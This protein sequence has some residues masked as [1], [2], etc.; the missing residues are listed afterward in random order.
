[1]TKRALEGIRIV[2]LSRLLPGPYCSMILAD[3]G[4][5]V[6]KVEEPHLGDPTRW[7]PPQ[8]H[9]TGI[10]FLNLN[11][12]KRSLTLNLKDPRGVAL[13]HRLAQQ[14]DVI[15][16]TFRPGV[17]DRLGI[18]YEAIATV[19]PQIVYCSLTGYGQ[20][21]PY[22]D[23]SGHDLNYIGLAGILG[24]TADPQGRPTIPGTQMADLAGAMAAAIAILAALLARQR[25]GH[26]QYIDVAMT[27]VAVGL[28]TIAA[29]TTFAGHPLPVGGRFELNGLFPFFNIYETSDGGFISLGALE[30]KF[31]QEFCRVVGRDD[32]VDKQ[33]AS[34][35]ERE[36]LFTELRELFRS[37]SR[38]EWEQI[39]ADADA[40]CEPILSLDEA[41]SHPQVQHRQMVVEVSQPE[42]GAVRHLASP[43]K[44]S[45]TPPSIRTPAPRLG[46]HTLTI[47]R[48]LGYTEAECQELKQAGVI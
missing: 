28:L 48:Q 22:R 17:V 2:D 1:M 39:F 37:K 38:Q 3:L 45:E 7:T 41:F 25:L 30:P 26:G 31:W 27:D 18:G 24:L 40:C 6:I 44:L 9:D 20:S 11:R 42:G 14:A 43:L 47:L 34:G 36:Q 12:N 35:Q 13:F 5:D 10:V 4:A 29:A 46:E 8:V 15:L 19:N 23:R 16:E 32:W 33:F 21:G